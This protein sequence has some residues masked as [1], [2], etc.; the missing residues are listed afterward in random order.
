MVQQDWRCLWSA[1]IQV[2]SWA[3]TVGLGSGIAAA[4]V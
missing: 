4:V 1:G 3:G 2:Q